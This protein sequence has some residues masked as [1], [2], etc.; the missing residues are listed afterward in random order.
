MLSIKA[1]SNG[2]R[3]VHKPLCAPNMFA[4]TVIL[5]AAMVLSLTSATPT[6]F[7]RRATTCSPPAATNVS[8][9]TSN[10]TNQDGSSPA[11]PMELGINSLNDIYL[12]VMW[13]P[14]APVGA[15]NLVPS[16]SQFIIEHSQLPEKPLTAVQAGGIINLDVGPIN[17][18]LWDIICTT[19][20]EDGFATDCTL[21]NFPFRSSPIQNQVCIANVTID[22]LGYETQLGDC[23]GDMGT[24]FKIDYHLY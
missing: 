19:C 10:L 5:L 23:A 12:I 18:Q 1:S 22:E 17:R 24:T 16:G 8:F 3:F 11:G 13:V 7:S 15:W 4:S 14:P 20:P 9:G 2:A 21:M 6:T